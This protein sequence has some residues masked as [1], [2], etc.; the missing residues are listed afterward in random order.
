MEVIDAAEN[1]RRYYMP[2]AEVLCPWLGLCGRIVFQALDRVHGRIGH[3]ALDRQYPM[4]PKPHH[5]VGFAVPE[6][7]FPTEL[8]DARRVVERVD[9]SRGNFPQGYAGERLLDR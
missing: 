2:I 4:V 5:N 8:A 9:R 3:L 6:Q 1:R 7:A